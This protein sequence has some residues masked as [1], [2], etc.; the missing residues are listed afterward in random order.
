MHFKADLDT[1][2]YDDKFE[3]SNHGEW[4]QVMIKEFYDSNRVHWRAVVDQI[5]KKGAS[6]I[7]AIWYFKRKRDIRTKQ[8]V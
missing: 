5:I 7:G 3:G 4:V 2:H 6:N 1:M 8:V